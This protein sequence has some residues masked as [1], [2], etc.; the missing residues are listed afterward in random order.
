QF[1]QRKNSGEKLPAPEKLTYLANCSNSASRQLYS[2]LGAKEIARAYELEEAPGAE[3]MRTKY[4]IK[5]EWGLCPN[6]KTRWA[7][8]KGYTN[9][10]GKISFTEPLYLLN[11][12][13]RLQLKFDCAN[14][15]MLIIG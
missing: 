6:Y 10:L 1:L 4:C 3:L 8:D 15:E 14:C 11:G 13:N 12:K 2:T 7:A 9:N 5:Y